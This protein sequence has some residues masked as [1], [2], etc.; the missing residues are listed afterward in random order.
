MNTPAQTKKGMASREELSV[1]VMAFWPKMIWL[2]PGLN[3]K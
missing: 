1:P 2:M 3:R